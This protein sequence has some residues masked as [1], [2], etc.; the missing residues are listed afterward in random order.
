MNALQLLWMLWL[1]FNNGKRLTKKNKKKII[2][3]CDTKMSY[4]KPTLCTMVVASSSI[5][6][7]LWSRRYRASFCF[8]YTHTHA[9][10][11]QHTHTATQTHSN[12]ITHRHMARHTHTGSKT[13]R[14]GSKLLNY[15][16]AWSRLSQEPGLPP[17][18][19]EIKVGEPMADRLINP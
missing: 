11:R 2:I 16:E 6:S 4:P 10:T 17:T 3:W 5:R 7:S 19:T 13:A 14:A 18:D 9:R 8:S 12:T 15:N 1:C